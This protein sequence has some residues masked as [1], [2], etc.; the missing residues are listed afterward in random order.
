VA[1]GACV[2]GAAQA[3]KSKATSN[4]IENA[5]G[6][7]LI[8]CTSLFSYRDERKT[9]RR[10]LY[11]DKTWQAPGIKLPGLLCGLKDRRKCRNLQGFR[12]NPNSTAGLIG[13]IMEMGQGFVVILVNVPNEIY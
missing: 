2:A 12:K 7:N 8:C 9:W 1:E 3:L 6:R 11:Q 10:F 5:L 4:R 13:I